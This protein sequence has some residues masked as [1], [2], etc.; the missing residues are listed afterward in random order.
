[1]NDRYLFKAKSVDNG[2]WICGSLITGV[3]HREENGADTPY[4]LNVDKS[5]ATCFED[6]TEGGEYFEVNP[7]TICQCTGLKDKNG[8][9][10]WEN[11]IIEVAGERYLIEWQDDSAMWVLNQYGSF[12]ASFDNY[13][14][15]EVEVIGN[16]FDDPELLESEAGK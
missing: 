6:F 9:L 7:E 13:W 14:S 12:V 3:F 4:I 15:D 2:E 11:D 16:K 5:N 10:T 8:K 1:M